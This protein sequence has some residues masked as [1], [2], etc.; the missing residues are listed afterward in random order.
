MNFMFTFPTSQ[1]FEAKWLD[2]W[3]L[4]FKRSAHKEYV[5]E[6]LFLRP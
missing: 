4:F 6:I 3:Y 1:A 2:S 5:M